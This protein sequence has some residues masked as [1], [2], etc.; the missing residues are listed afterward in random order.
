MLIPGP[1][2][3]GDAIDIYL[4]RLIEELKELWEVGIET[5]DASSRQNFK[6][7]ASL[8]WTINDF[9][10][11]GNLSGWSTKGKLVRP[12]CNKDTSSIRLANSK[13]Q[14]FMGH[15]RYLPLS[16]KWRND[17][18]SFDGTKEKRL[19]PKMCSGI[20]IL[21]QLQDLEGIQLTK[22]LKKRKKISHENRKDNWNKKNHKI[23]GLKSHDFH[24]LLQHILPLALRG[25][26]SKEVCEP[27]IELSLFFNVLGS[28]EL[29]IDDLEQIEAQ[30]PI[31]LCK[32]EK[33]FPPSFFDVMV[34]LPIHL[35]SEAKIAGPIHYRWMYPVEQW[36]NFLKSLI[37]N[38]ACPEGSIAEGYI[39]NECMTLCSREFAQTH[40]DTAQHL[41]DAK[42]NRTLGFHVKDYDNNL[43]TQNCSVIV[44]GENDKDS[45]NI[46]YYGILTDVIE[47]QFVMGGRVILFRCNWFDVYD[48]IKRVKKDEYEFVS[49]NL[50]RF[51]N[52]NEPFILAEQASQV[53]Y[54]IDNSNKGWHI[55]RKTQPRDSYEI[56]K[57]MDDDIVDLG[58]PS[59]KKRKRTDEVKFNM[60]PSKTE[61]EVE[62]TMKSTTRYA[63]V[64]LGTIRKGQGRGRGRGRGLRSLVEKENMPTKSL[65]PQSIDLVKQYIQTI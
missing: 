35:A 6:L 8:L 23:P 21:N 10:A 32:L 26:L 39:A 42:W 12:C 43:R 19:P 9:L 57:Q 11:Y 31:T 4:Q 28:K 60:K 55:V 36:L 13:K 3:P 38:R 29:R 37:D 24:V 61:N 25:M 15:R 44:V 5:F 65:F 56:V 34:H 49:V 17:K 16:H 46:D 63:F 7:H 58:N 59:Q 48:K 41:S 40:V 53:F 20:E 54:A 22:D 1:G 52:T 62:S 2:S 45:E 51:L 47:L 64:P 30:I 50:R 14:Y 27:V 18:D 33:V